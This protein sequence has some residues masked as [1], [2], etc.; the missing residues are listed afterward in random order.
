MA[1]T[2]LS[3]HKPRGRVVSAANFDGHKSKPK[4]K[5]IRNRAGKQ[6]ALVVAALKLFASKGYDATTTR[7]IA[8][9]AGCAEG[10]IHRYFNGKAGLLPALTTYR[11]SKQVA[12]L[13]QRVPPA[14]SLEDEY[15]QL[16]KWAVEQMWADRDFLKVAIPQAMLDPDFGYVLRRTGPL[17][18]ERIISARLRKFPEC[19]DLSD[20]DMDTLVQFVNVMGFMFGFM[21]PAVLRQDRK[22]AAKTAASIAKLVVRG[23]PVDDSIVQPALA[24]R[25]LSAAAV[26]SVS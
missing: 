20:D 9:A 13:T 25:V 1:S 12:D 15:I 4:P 3:G 11:I 14:D 10:L 24:E 23:L 8:A 16:V 17:E 6:E 26:L 19:R 2:N 21:R 5:R 7:E 22:A 18:R